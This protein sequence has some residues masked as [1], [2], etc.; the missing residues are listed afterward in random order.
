MVRPRKFLFGRD[1]AFE[2]LNHT[3]Q[4]DDHCPYLCRFTLRSL[5]FNLKLTLGFHLMLHGAQVWHRLEGF[6]A[7]PE[8][9][10]ARTLPTARRP[11]IER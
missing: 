6:L 5:A 11:M 3:I 9:V 8:K 7:C 4:V 10:V 1:V 2:E